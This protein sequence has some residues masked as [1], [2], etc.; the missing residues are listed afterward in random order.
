MMHQEPNWSRH[1]RLYRDRMNGGNHMVAVTPYAD[2]FS[3]AEI[4]FDELRAEWRLT[5]FD[6]V[7]RIVGDDERFETVADARHQ[8]DGY[9][10][11]GR[12]KS[13]KVFTKDDSSYQTMRAC[14]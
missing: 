12:L 6:I 7:G 9:F 2:E 3:R 5:V 10:G 4:W 8:V 1:L 14:Q 13:C 11:A